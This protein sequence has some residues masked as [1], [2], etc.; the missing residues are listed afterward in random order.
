MHKQ[1]STPHLIHV[2]MPIINL[3]DGALAAARRVPE[4][5][6]YDNLI[7]SVCSQYRA[8]SSAKVMECPV[9]VMGGV[10]NGSISTPF[11]DIQAPIQ[12]NLYPT[13]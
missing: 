12:A 8:E 1:H 13:N 7:Y 2:R 6:F 9:P 5:L 3:S 10:L 4:Y 11:P